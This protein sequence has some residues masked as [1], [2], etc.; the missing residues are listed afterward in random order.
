MYSIRAR[1]FRVWWF[2]VSFWVNRCFPLVGLLRDLLIILSYY[3][4]I[5]PFL[6]VF[7]FAVF[8][9]KMFVFFASYCWCFRVI[10]SQLSIEISSVYFECPAFSI[11]F[12]PLFILFIF[13]LFPVIFFLKLYYYFDFFFTQAWK[14]F[15]VAW[16]TENIF[17]IPG[18]FRV[19]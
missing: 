11:L 10:S 4:S 19:F 8:L 14:S 3:L 18:L 5:Q 15:S 2:F 7:S 16:V 13:L 9:S 6:C 12:Y 1:R 17:K